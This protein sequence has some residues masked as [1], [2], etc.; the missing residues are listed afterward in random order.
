M[1][2]HYMMFTYLVKYLY[3]CIYIYI[4]SC[5]LMYEYM[6][7]EEYSCIYIQLCEDGILWLL[8][9]EDTNPTHPSIYHNVNVR[10]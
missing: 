9:V 7:V 10:M 3:V 2:L 5:K 8:I 6:F 4:S 1:Y